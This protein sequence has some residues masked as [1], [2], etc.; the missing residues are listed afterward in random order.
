MFKICSIIFNYVKRFFTFKK[1]MC[2]NATSKLTLHYINDPSTPNIK[3]NVNL[4]VNNFM[5]LKVNNMTNVGGSVLGSVQWQADNAYI[6]LTNCLNSLQKFFPSNIK[7]W[8]ATNNLVVYPRA[9]K[10]ANAYYDRSSLKFFYFNSYADGKLIYS[11]ESSDIV[12]HELGH[13]ILDAI[14]PDFWNAAA[15]EIGAFHE[16]FGDLIALLNILQ[17]DS[18]IN[19]ILI[20]TKGNLRQNNFVSELAEHFGSA[21]KIPHGLR[22]AFNSESYV[23]PDFLPSDGKGLIKEIHSFSVVWTGAFYDIFVSIY[24]KLGKTKASLIQ[25]RDIVTKLLF[26]SVTKVPATVKFFNSL[27]K[28]MIA[29]DKKING[30]LYSSILIDVFK[31]RN[32]LTASD[33]Q[34]LSLSNISILSAEKENYLFV[35]KKEIFVNSNSNKIKVQLACDSFHDDEKNKLNVL[36]VFSDEIDSYQEAESFVNYLFSK[37]LIGNDKKHNWFIDKDNDNKLTRIKMQSD[38]GFINN[39]TIEGQPEY[40]K[41]WKPDNNSG[42]CPYGCPKTENEEPTNYKSCAVRYSACNNNVTSSSCNNKIL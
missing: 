8:A 11:V 35:S 25:A 41:C 30:K 38:F 15:F 40:K 17:Y 9:G 12:T 31:K 22:N 24:E 6:S 27:A 18:V 28:C 7:K 29:T 10:D 26:E 23:N 36:S 16:S 2:V 19:T 4:P 3:E 14:R 34:Q 37:D 32:I 5:K 33:V 39:C 20:D 1:P 21:L 13:A 42:C